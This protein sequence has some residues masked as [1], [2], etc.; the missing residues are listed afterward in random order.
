MTTWHEFEPKLNSFTPDQQL[1]LHTLGDLISERQHQDL[2]I[3]SLAMKMN[4]STQ[5][6]I[7]LEQADQIPSL[8]QLTDY[9]AGLGVTL[10]LSIHAK[11]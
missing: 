5:S 4:V 7:T 6:L 8:H 1:L 2:S 3:P 10:D 9:A 11:I